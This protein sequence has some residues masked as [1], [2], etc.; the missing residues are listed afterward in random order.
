MDCVEI[1]KDASNSHNS[2]KP[3]PSRLG[4]TQFVNIVIHI[5]NKY[6]M[7]YDKMEKK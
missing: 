3:K 7:M 6:D 1:N 4:L 2:L 5:R